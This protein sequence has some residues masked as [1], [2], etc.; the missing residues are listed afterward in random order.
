MTL[1]EASVS[2]KNTFSDNKKVCKKENAENVFRLSNT[3][4]GI[5]TFDLQYSIDSNG[6]K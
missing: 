4:Y 2:T 1:N 5:Y 3:Y 6:N